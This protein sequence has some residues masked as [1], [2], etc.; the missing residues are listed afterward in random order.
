MMYLFSGGRLS[1]KQ[2]VLTKRMCFKVLFADSS[3]A[4]TAVYLL[5]EIASHI[6]VVLSV[7]VCFMLIAVLT[8]AQI[9]TA[10]NTAWSFRPFRH[11]ITYTI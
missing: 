5:A 1:F 3:P 11:I 9:W 2:A 6:P 8:V 4:F 10:G 7:F